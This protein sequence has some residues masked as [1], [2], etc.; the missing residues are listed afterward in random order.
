MRR[1]DLDALVTPNSELIMG[2][3]P[4]ASAQSSF[5]WM[6][7][8]CTL[9]RAADGSLI[10]PWSE[11]REVV[12]TWREKGFSLCFYSLKPP[13]LRLRFA[14]A[15]TTF[16]S[17]LQEWLESAEERNV[18]RG[19]RPGRYEPEAAR[20][21]GRAGMALAHGWFN[22]DSCA[23]LAYAALAPDE[24][25]IGRL[26]LSALIL[27]RLFTAFAEDPAELWD[28]W[29]QVA[30]RLAGIQATTSQ[31][32]PA[33]QPSWFTDE[34]VATLPA[35]VRSLLRGSFAASEGV[36]RAARLLVDE[37]TP[38]VVSGRAWA[39]EAA[40]FHANRLGLAPGELSGLSGR[41]LDLFK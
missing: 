9:F 28:T 27:D 35:A 32:F 20:F 38:R 37:P 11:L 25:G 24:R 7:I 16:L 40:I 14:Q 34:F 39:V 1:R 31:E 23:L 15:T 17:I 3:W 6:Q 29:A 21:G 5:E 13:G 26:G 41:M 36:A 33:M 12:E 8:D 22:A 30:A 2:G 19:F 18:L 4:V 10:V